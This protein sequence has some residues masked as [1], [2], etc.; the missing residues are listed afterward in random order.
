M[1][2][3]GFVCLFVC[4]LVILSGR[5]KENMIM[6]LEV[7][8]GKLKTVL[9]RQNVTVHFSRNKLSRACAFQAPIGKGLQLHR[10]Q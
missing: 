4:F 6:A 8:L 9:S 1:Y 2:V 7:Y 10:R 3:V 5:K